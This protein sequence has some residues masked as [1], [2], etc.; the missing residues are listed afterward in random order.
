[1]ISVVVPSLNSSAYLSEALRSALNQDVDLEVVVQ[2]GGSTDATSEIV[3]SFQ[4]PRV[5]F[6]RARDAGQADAVNR[7]VAT[8]RGEWI[9]WLNADD[10]LLPGALGAVSDMLEHNADVVYGDSLLIGHDGRVLRQYRAPRRI[11]RTYVL[12]HGMVIFSGSMILRRS[13]FLEWGGLDTSLSFCMDFE[14]LARIA[15]SPRLRYAPVVIGAFRVHHASKTGTESWAFLRESRGVRSRFAESNG[16][17]GELL[18]DA[19]FA[20]YILTSPLRYSRAWS[21]VR[22]IKQR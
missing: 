8:A 17:L 12:R 18:H 11:S 9:V 3:A 14:L 19:R 13:R 5:R 21:A 10:L 7:G 2:D 1:M 6:S 4:D 15:D 22:K 20:T 16:R